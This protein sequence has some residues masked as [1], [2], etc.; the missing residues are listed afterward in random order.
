V[1]QAEAEAYFAN[2]IGGFGLRLR[3]PARLSNPVTLAEMRRRWPW[4]SP[5]QS[6]RFV[7]DAF[8]QEL[9]H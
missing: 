1:T 9:G 8:L 7:N 4:L 5:P 3:K 6:Y 2:T